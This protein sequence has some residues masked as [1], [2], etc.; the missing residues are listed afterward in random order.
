MCKNLRYLNL[1][2]LPVTSAGLRSLSTISHELIALN[3]DGC[4]GIFDK[5]LQNVFIHSPHLESVTLS[6]NSALTGKCLY[7]L[8]FAPLKELV[9]DECNNL[10]SQNLVNVLPLLTDLNR[11]SLNSCI[12]LKSRDVAGVIGALPKLRS[13]SI[14]GYFPFFTSTTLTLLG[15][16]C[17]LIS[18]NLHLNPAVNDEI[19]EVITTRCH[20]IEELNI[21]G[22]RR[23]SF[24]ISL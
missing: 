15:Q 11:L 17:D 18:L 24:Y 5:G 13:L 20:R 22:E 2:G 6:H 9:L 1:A 3:L 12:N 7:C 4:S 19:M 14:A 23:V 10:Q 16:L 8:A 21:T